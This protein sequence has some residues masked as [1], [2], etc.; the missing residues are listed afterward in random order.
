MAVIP[1]S[2]LIAW[3]FLG[4]R[5]TVIPE[6]CDVID[7][8]IHPFREPPD[9]DSAPL[10]TGVIVSL[11]RVIIG[12]AIASVI[13]IPAGIGIGS[14]QLTK[15]LFRPIFSVMMVVSPIA[16]MPLAIIAFRFSSVG[17]IFWGEE[18]WRFD[19]LDQLSIAVIVI[20]A[21]GAFFPIVVNTSAGVSGVRKAHVES[22]RILGGSRWDIFCKVTVP[23]SLPSIMTGV[24]LGGGISW[25]V[26]VASE[27]FPGIRSGLGH[28][29]LTSQQQAEYRYTYAAI[30]VIAAIGLAIDLT[31]AMIEHRTNRWKR[32]ER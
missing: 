23:S 1:V 3:I 32:N 17:T 13:A 6:I 21:T 8:I 31:L 25:R 30:V 9:L 18:H 29:I 22:I 7:V 11:L 4:G 2:L 12:F 24:R 26:M 16:W 14:S 28:M 10:A 20:I 15:D 5:Y 19:I 27:F